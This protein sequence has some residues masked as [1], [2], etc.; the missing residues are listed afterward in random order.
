MIEEARLRVYKSHVLP[1][2]DY[3]DVLYCK[4]PTTILEELQRVQ[5]K[6]LKTCLSKHIL[7]PTEEVHALAGLPMLSER[8]KFHTLVYAYKRSR[9]VR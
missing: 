3:C 5:N 6:C 7:T 1:V 4:A 2:I 8:R 9:D